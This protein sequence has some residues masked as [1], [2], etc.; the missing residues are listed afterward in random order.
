[1]YP[2]SME[3]EFEEIL[4][5]MRKEKQFKFKH[6]YQDIYDLLNEYLDK[7]DKVKYVVRF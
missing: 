2:G 1:M 3:K 7:I 6:N 4:Q 5:E